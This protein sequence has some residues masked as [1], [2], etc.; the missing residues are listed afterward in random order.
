[1]NISLSIRFRHGYIIVKSKYTGAAGII[2]KVSSLNVT[3]SG[4]RVISLVNIF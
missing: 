4:G 3:E 2:Y 1:M